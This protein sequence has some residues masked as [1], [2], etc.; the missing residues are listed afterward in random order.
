MNT[1]VQEWAN[2]ITEQVRKETLQ[3]VLTT[4]NRRAN[5]MDNLLWSDEAIA[6]YH[7]ATCDRWTK[8]YNHRSRCQA[9]CHA[10]W[11]AAGVVAKMLY[12]N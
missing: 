11:Q 8:L 7:H 10:A 6:T 9:K 2:I 12:A 3:E 1:T 5:M 4:L